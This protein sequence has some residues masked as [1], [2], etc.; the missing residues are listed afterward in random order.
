VI[1]MSRRWG[2]GF[3][4]GVFYVED[5]FVDVFGSLL[6]HILGLE[7]FESGLNTRGFEVICEFCC[8][9]NLE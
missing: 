4:C 3:D 2:N 1:F 5:G 9:E 8:S 7:R 6:L